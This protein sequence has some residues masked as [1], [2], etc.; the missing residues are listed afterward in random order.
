MLG[1]TAR[2]HRRDG[3]ALVDRVALL[4]FDRPEVDERDGIPVSREDR[5]A[6][7]VGRERAGEAHGAGRRRADRRR[8]GPR[9]VDPAVLPRGIGVAPEREGPEDVAVRGP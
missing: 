6:A 4:D 3:G 5:E 2:P 8:V 1:L 9:D 7:P